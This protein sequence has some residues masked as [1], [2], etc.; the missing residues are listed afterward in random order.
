MRVAEAETITRVP[1]TTSAGTVHR[2]IAHLTLAVQCFA[3][4]RGDADH[5][6][7]ATRKALRLAEAA[8]RWIESSR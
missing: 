8:L 3:Q 1:T 5:A 6:L 4:V 2:G 7:A